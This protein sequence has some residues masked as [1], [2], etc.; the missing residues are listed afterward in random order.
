MGH[1]SAALA[2]GYSACQIKGEGGKGGRERMPGQRKGLDLC[3][4]T[5]QL[6]RENK[7]H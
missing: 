4:A 3:T 2:K 1:L 6:C 5:V 7:Q